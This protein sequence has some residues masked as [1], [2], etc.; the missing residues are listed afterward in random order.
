MKLQL[1]PLVIFVSDVMWM[2]PDKSGK[3]DVCLPGVSIMTI[4]VIKQI[5]NNY[6]R[7]SYMNMY[8]NYV[9][10]LYVVLVRIIFRN[11]NTYVSYVKH[12][13]YHGLFVTYKYVSSN[14]SI[15][16]KH[17]IICI[18]IVVFTKENF[19]NLRIWVKN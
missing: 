2:N 1:C 7:T 6:K 14:D 16:L 17:I 12:K 10:L 9:T 8:I 13:F 19:I 4:F 15:P 3:T 11:N 5:F 18:T